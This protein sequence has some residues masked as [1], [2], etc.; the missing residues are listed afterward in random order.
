MRAKKEARNEAI[1][2]SGS[3]H[4]TLGVLQGKKTP[5]KKLQKAT[6]SKSDLTKKR[7]VLF[8]T[9]RSFKRKK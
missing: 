8:E 9:L 6:H 3:L 7:A 4:K 5:E 1:G 2:H